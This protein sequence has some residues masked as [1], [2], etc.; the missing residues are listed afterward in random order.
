MHHL[1]KN[2]SATIRC[3][4]MG[5]AFL[6][7]TRLEQGACKFSSEKVELLAIAVRGCNFV[8][9]QLLTPS[10]SAIPDPHFGPIGDLLS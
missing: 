8:S 1:F 3:G 7:L 4:N 10:C 2:S 5:G 6:A 9:Q